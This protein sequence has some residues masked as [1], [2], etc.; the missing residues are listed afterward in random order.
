MVEHNLHRKSFKTL[1]KIWGIHHRVTPPTNAQSNGQAE[2][3]VQT[4]KNSL[5]KA[6]EGGEDPHLAILTYATTPLNHS[7]PS[8]AELLNS[9]K[10][11]C[12]LPVRVS[13]QNHTHRYRD[14]MQQQKR[15]QM[16]YYN[17]HAR[18]LPSLKTRQPVY[19]QL[20]PKTRNWTQGHV[21]ERL[22]Q[23]TYKVKTYNGGTYT[24]NRKFIKPRYIDSRQSLQ[25]SNRVTDTQKAVV[26]TIRIQSA[27]KNHQKTTET[28]R[29]H[30]LKS[31]TYICIYIYYL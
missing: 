13:Q 7:L 9:R 2:R 26:V 4:I 3:F 22:S 27:K 11:R 19:V 1:Q 8:P 24:R 25:T 29:D 21:I 17:R 12:I 31:C 15:Q 16:H 28:N 5:T 30:E 18:D 10:Y 6:M 20:V 14:T 23:R